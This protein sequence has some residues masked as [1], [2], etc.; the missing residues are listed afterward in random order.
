MQTSQIMRWKATDQMLTQDQDHNRRSELCPV[1]LEA[2]H[3]CVAACVACVL[4]HT[5]VTQMLCG[6]S[7]TSPDRCP[8]VHTS[9]SLF[10]AQQ[11]STAET[12]AFVSCALFTLLLIQSQHH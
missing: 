1:K 2:M 4:E 8:L 7:G 12:I 9:A 5:R 10:E 11:P 6:W 3:L